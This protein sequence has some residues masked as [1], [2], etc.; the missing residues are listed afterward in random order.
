[1]PTTQP[2]NSITWTKLRDDSWGIRGA[3]LIEGE[4]V[5]VTKRSGQTKSVMV[6]EIVWTGQDSR[7]GQQTQIARV[8]KTQNTQSPQ[9]SR[10]RSCRRCGCTDPSCGGSGGGICRG[11]SF[12]PCHDCE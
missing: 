10:S 6:G 2:T 3:G 12:N 11:P 7:T 5:T 1:M 9:R 8:S 4:T